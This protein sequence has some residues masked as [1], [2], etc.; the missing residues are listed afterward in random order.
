MRGETPFLHV[1]QSDHAART[2]YR[3]MGF[4]DHC[5]TPVR[6]ISRLPPASSPARVQNGC[7]TAS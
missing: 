2:L 3:Q 7:G 4:R 5:L 6:I 1:L